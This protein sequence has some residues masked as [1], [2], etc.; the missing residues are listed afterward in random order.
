MQVVL[1]YAIKLNCLLKK[2]LDKDF[3]EVVLCFGNKIKKEGTLLWV[4]WKL[5]QVVENFV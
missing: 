4:I 3:F 1:N 5:D 2:A